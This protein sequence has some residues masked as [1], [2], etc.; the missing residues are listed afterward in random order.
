MVHH[1]SHALLEWKNCADAQS[2]SIPFRDAISIRTDVLMQHPGMPMV[3]RLPSWSTRWQ[4][5]KAVADFKTSGGLSV[6]R[7]LEELDIIGPQC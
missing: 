7:A 5:R 6:S 3:R 4:S 2:K 1:L